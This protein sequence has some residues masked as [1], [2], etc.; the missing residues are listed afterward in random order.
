MNPDAPTHA[1][2][3]A[4]DL[5]DHVDNAEHIVINFFAACGLSITDR[6]ACVAA[7]ADQ[8]YDLAGTG[9]ADRT[10]LLR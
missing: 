10:G 2:A 9:P 1:E 5:G 8:L 7:L 3:R 4:D 6:L